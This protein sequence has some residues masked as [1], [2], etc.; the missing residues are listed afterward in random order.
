MVNCTCIAKLN[1]MNSHIGL[2]PAMAAPT[3]RPAK[4]ASVIGASMT[5]EEP[6]L[7]KRPLLT[8]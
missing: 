7:P 1:V 2:R 8:L 6:N 3:V 5:L 4:P